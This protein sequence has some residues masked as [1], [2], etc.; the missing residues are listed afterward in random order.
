V[1]RTGFWLGTSL[2]FL[3]LF[4]SPPDGLSVAGWRTA[5]VAVLV[6]CWWFTEAVPVTLTGALPFLVLP[7]LGVAKPE[8]VASQYMGSILFLV[9]GG[10][11]LGVAMEKWGL[12]R[13]IAVAVIARVRPEPGHLLFAIMVVTA[14]V[15]MW[16][17]NSS[18]T[19][20]MLPIATATIHAVTRTLG[21]A[22]PDPQEQRFAA[23]VVLSVAYASN[24]GGFATPIGTP[25]NP[26]AIGIIDKTFGIHVSFLQ[27]MAFGVPIML[28]ALPATWWLLS[29]VSFP[30]RLPAGDRNQLIEAIGRPGNLT[31]P[32]MR[33]AAVVAA[34]SL[35]WVAQ[36]ALA[37]LIP[38]LTDAGIAIIGALSLCLIPAGGEAAG[39]R[40]RFLLEWPEA[41]E[42]P[43]Y[44]IMLLGGGLALADSI[45][46]TGLSGWIGNELGAAAALPWLLLLL[47]VT[48]VCVAV[49]ECASN[50]AT[51]ASFIPVAATL[52]VVGGHDGIALSLAAGMAASWGFANPAGTSS[53]AMVYGTG[54]ISIRDMLRA[55]LLVDVV[56][57]L[58]I[59]AACAVIVPWLKLG[60]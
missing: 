17:N 24:I 45:V 23:A 35:M 25:V 10:A 9:L 19:V 32:E 8:A 49:T 58:L 52:A 14:I 16:V 22:T 5:A 7:L 3:M 26:I 46:K 42:A 37:A 28:L 2:F 43:W 12:H 57:V 59:A 51:A 53:N 36:P 30:F 33:V 55:G 39:S 50:I 29:R 34:T 27:W 1:Q 20:M 54:R 44:L 15:S 21:S 18:T 40:R 4:L 47:L 6:A 13:R 31:T 56:G 48:L 11:M 38:G 60:G 41:R